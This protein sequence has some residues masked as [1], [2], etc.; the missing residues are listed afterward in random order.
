MPLSI[1]ERK[2][3]IIDIRDGFTR[4]DLKQLLR[5]DFS[6]E[7]EWVVP[8]A[9]LEAQVAELISYCERHE[10][11]GR[12]L[13]AAAGRRPQ[14]ANL[15]HLADLYPPM[16]STDRPTL[17][18]IN[19][20]TAAFSAVPNLLQAN[21]QILDR[22]KPFVSSYDVAERHVGQLQRYKK[23][24]HCLHIIELM[25]GQIDQAIGTL[26]IA[27][28]AVRGAVSL[29]SVTGQ[30]KRAGDL[31]DV[32]S[33]LENPDLEQT[34]LDYVN[35][36]IEMFQSA[37]DRRDADQAAIGYDLLKR[38]VAQDPF[39][40]QQLIFGEFEK[41]PMAGLV[42]SLRVVQD[43]PA[44]PAVLETVKLGLVAFEQTQRKL[45]LLVHE[46]RAWQN[47]D[48]SLRY[49]RQAYQ[50]V[51]EYLSELPV[52][53]GK[54]PSLAAGG[55]GVAVVMENPATASIDKRLGVLFRALK[56][57]AAKF[58]ALQR[59]ASAARLGDLTSYANQFVAAVSANDE[60]AI[61]EPF[62]SFCGLVLNT[63]VAVDEE[64][65]SLADNLTR[66]GT[67]LQAILR[68]LQC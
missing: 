26:G 35:Q 67:P 38:V 47:L 45:A 1:G 68:I 61:A 65:L 30:L 43:A 2:Q 25:E 21:S 49:A 44:H 62:E 19:M 27:R 55:G 63:F 32:I 31:A 56:D 66:I 51:Y 53:G 58:V 57:V 39:R 24:H 64:L 17:D 16:E 23:L 12:L 37:A 52:G 33:G 54:A 8:E 40:I 42:F 4:A 13:N 3:A 10:L 59:Y 22:F 9:G 20:A 5:G 50:P 48:N 36:A 28:S 29:R 11:I 18:L 6:M 46:H 60:A 34:W 7:L 41:I 14:N 15:R